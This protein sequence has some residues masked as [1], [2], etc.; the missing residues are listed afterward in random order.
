[1]DETRPLGRLSDM[2]TLWTLVCKAHQGPEEGMRVARQRLLARYDRAV[3]R[4]L[5][6][7]LRDADTADELAQEFRLRFLRGDFRKADPGRGR[8]RDYVKTALFRLVVQYRRRQQKQPRT[9]GSQAPEPAV[10]DPSV[11]AAEEEF[12]RSWRD[13]LLA[14]AWEDLRHVQEE[15][16]PPWYTVLRFRADHPDVPS[17]QMAEQLTTRLGKPLTAA[18]VRQLLHRA[19]EKFADLL[20]EQVVHSLDRP[21]AE[22]LEAEL[23]ELNL[24]QYC[25]PALKRRG[26]GG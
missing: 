19:R 24:Y 8:F 22:Q 1:M 11:D 25:Q 14:A 17:P 18:G 13:A 10:T 26:L 9:L 6:G 2:T 4:Y 16:G 7:A 20:L 15:N 23:I 5:A 12:F 21:T 3:H